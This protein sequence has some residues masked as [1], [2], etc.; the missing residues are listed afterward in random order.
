MKRRGETR[1]KP[2]V[3]NGILR[4]SRLHANKIYKDEFYI[5]NSSNI[6]DRSSSSSDMDDVYQVTLLNVSDARV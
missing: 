6:N 2:L 3:A 5:S 1:R 4:K